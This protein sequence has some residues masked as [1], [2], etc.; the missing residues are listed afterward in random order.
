MTTDPSAGPVSAEEIARLE[1]MARRIRVAVIRTVANRKVGHVGGPLSSADILAALYGRIM[2]I[3]P[4][5]PDW[6][7]RDRFILSKGHSALGQYANAQITRLE[8]RMSVPARDR[9]CMACRNMRCSTMFGLG[10]LYGGSSMRNEVGFA[11]SIVRLS[12]KAVPTAATMPRPS[13]A[14]KNRWE[15]VR[16]RPRP[17]PAL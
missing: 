9:K 8:A 6:P 2:R 15:K 1:D 11:L 14:P 16:Q 13:S 7:D 10:I 3:R 5:E 12:R 4:D 17:R